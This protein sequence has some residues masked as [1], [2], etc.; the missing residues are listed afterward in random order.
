MTDPQTNIRRRLPR[1][2]NPLRASAESKNVL[3]VGRAVSAVAMLLQS[4]CNSCVRACPAGRGPVGQCD[5]VN[6]LSGKHQPCRSRNTP[7]SLLPALSPESLRSALARCPLLCFPIGSVCGRSAPVATR[8]ETRN[9]SPRNTSPNHA[10]QHFNAQ[11]G[12]LRPIK[13]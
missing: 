4:A 12:A 1:Q 5:V 9:H 2:T 8:P 10:R 3:V 7:L 6:I 13:F 11:A